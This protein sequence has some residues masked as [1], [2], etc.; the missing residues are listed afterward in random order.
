M[1]IKVKKEMNYYELIKWAWKNGVK[2]TTFTSDL[3]QTVNF[4][5][6]G[7][8]DFLGSSRFILKNEKF[9]VEVEEEITEET[10]ISTLIELNRGEFQFRYDTF[11]RES[12]NCNSD[13]FYILNDDMTM[14][15][16]WTRD[17]GLVQ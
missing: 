13:A 16:V 10:D 4:D 3:G 2:N 14:T 6:S 8:L 17:G 12:K 1:K 11:L 7:D 15:L 5:S 9:A